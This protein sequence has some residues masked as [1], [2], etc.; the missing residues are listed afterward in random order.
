MPEASST[1]SAS[2]CM[3]YFRSSISKT[4]RPVGERSVVSF[5]LEVFCLWDSA[6]LQMDQI[7][8]LGAQRVI[9]VSYGSMQKS[10]LVAFGV[11]PAAL[12][13]VILLSLHPTSVAGSNLC[14]KPR[15]YWVLSWRAITMQQSLLY[16]GLLS[17][18][19]D[20]LVAGPALTCYFDLPLPPM[21]CKACDSLR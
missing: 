12:V 4:S 8:A 19:A 3:R 16:D 7:L 17:F 14:T 15:C 10:R 11:A 2:S 6:M 13:P 18:L 5:Y 1:T 9:F 21:S 20:L